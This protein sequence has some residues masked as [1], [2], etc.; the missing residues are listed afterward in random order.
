MKNKLRKVISIILEND[1]APQD[2]RFNDSQYGPEDLRSS[3]GGRVQHYP[4]GEKLLNWMRTQADGF[5]VGYTE[6]AS[7]NHM[8]TMF[9]GSNVS[10][11]EVKRQH[12][13]L[14][15][16]DQEWTAASNYEINT[17]LDVLSPQINTLLSQAQAA[18]DNDNVGQ[19]LGY[20]AQIDS[21]NAIDAANEAATLGKYQ[22][23]FR[24]FNALEAYIRSAKIIKDPFQLDDPT[25]A[26]AKKAEEKRKREQAAKEAKEFAAIEKE[27]EKLKSENKELDSKRLADTAKMILGLGF[28]IATA[29]AILNVFAGPA[30]EAA[31]QLA[32]RGVQNSIDDVAKLGL[33]D[34]ATNKLAKQ[35]TREN[36]GVYNPFMTDAQ[37]KL[38][39]QQGLGMDIKKITN[40]Y[41]SKGQVLSENRKRILR[42]IKKPYV[43]PEIPKQKYKMNFSGKF[44]SQNTPDITSSSKSDELVAFG[45]ANGQRW[46]LDD[47]Y[48]QGYETTEKMN[49]VYDKVGHGNQAWE[50]IIDEARIKNGWRTRE[51]QEHLN[52]IIHEKVMIDE[53]PNYTSP[54]IAVESIEIFGKE[55]LFK[56]LKKKMWKDYSKDPKSHNVKPQYPSEPP[57]QRGLDGWRPDYG[58]RKDY[59]KK[60][61]PHS[62]AAMPGGNGYD[63]NID[64][65]TAFKKVMARTR[66]DSSNK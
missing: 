34:P 63:P 5:I 4:E 3:G 27:I 11:Y 14:E 7:I 43:L 37:N 30:D 19:A 42:E 32:K 16:A 29:A 40:S 22:T 2:P 18:L 17:Y 54:F 9:Q 21:L 56:Q 64:A 44:K 24:L 33:R 52:M 12:D 25:V 50:R 28:D 53:D 8:V 39:K 38:A 35:F 60:L 49:V 20:L 58:D 57:V 62:A 26:A 31:L 6:G 66:V 61:D 51:I 1:P 15:I 45:N 13:N 48:W 59:Y 46:K 41:E 23:F 47:R 65:E 10:A 36:P 55:P